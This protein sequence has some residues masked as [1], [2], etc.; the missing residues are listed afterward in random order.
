MLHELYI[1]SMHIAAGWH[2][3]L[4][5]PLTM[6]CHSMLSGLQQALFQCIVVRYLGMQVGAK[7]RTRWLHEGQSAG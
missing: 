4:A 3:K 6:T 2:A 5:V 7:A 1:L